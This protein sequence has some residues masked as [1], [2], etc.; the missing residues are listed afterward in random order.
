VKRTKDA[1]PEVKLVVCEPFTLRVGSVDDSWFPAFDGYR[2]AARRVA[3]EAGA[4]FVPFQDMFDTA[5]KLAPANL[6]AADGVH[7]TADGAAIMAGRWLKVV[8]A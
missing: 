2:A 5:A 1:L 7:P 6:W 4:V 8:G 3:E